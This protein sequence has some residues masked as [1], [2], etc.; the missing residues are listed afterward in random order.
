MATAA[1]SG[2]VLAYPILW[3][4]DGSTS[5]LVVGMM[6]AALL[7]AATYGPLAALLTEMFG[8]NVRYTGASIGYQMAAM[9][10]GGFTPLIATELQ[11]LGGGSA[12]VSAFLAICFAIT[13]ASVLLI[14]ETSRRDLSGGQQPP[15]RGTIRTAGP[16]GAGGNP[17]KRLRKAA[18]ERRETRLR[19][20]IYLPIVGCV[21]WVPVFIRR[22]RAE[23][24][25][26]EWGF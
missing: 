25:R 5:G 3:L 26:T 2:V 24:G 14:G 21:A 7:Q 6:L 1:G 19:M 22:M 9:L 15:T 12:W 8:T 20:S 17:P 18:D 11:S 10:G 23:M 16:V 4:I 13:V